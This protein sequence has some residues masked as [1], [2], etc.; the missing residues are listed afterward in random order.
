MQTVKRLIIKNQLYITGAVLYAA[1]LSFII[2]QTGI[3]TINE[4][5]K[6]ISA[7]QRI[8]SIDFTV[9]IS[10]H[11]F[12]FSYILFTA[13]LLS[14]GNITTIVIVQAV[15]SFVASIC[16]KK[17]L[18]LLQPI[19]LISFAGM[20]MFLFCYPVQVWVATLFSDSFFVSL[21]AITLYYT[22]KVKTK[23]EVYLWIF[24]NATLLFARPPGVFLLLVFILFQ[25]YKSNLLSKKQIYISFLTGLT[26]LVLSVFFIPVENKGYIQ[27][28]AA[29]RIIVDSSSYSLPDFTSKSKTNLKVAYLYLYEKKGFKHIASLYV[30]KCLSF[31]TLTRPHYSARH[32]LIV[33][34]FYLIYPFF[35]IG[36]IYLWAYGK[37]DIAVLLCAGIFILLNLVALTFNEWHYRFTIPAFPFLIIGAACTFSFLH[38]KYVAGN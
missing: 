12:Y 2:K 33:Q 27:P 36:L 24:L 3:I 34:L 29:G 5:E 35:I 15:L 8:F 7:A 13:L 10:D 1:F 14:V 11:L 38:Q 19:K 23:A 22:I 32:N 28:V 4:A 17:T 21:I 30:K 20:L 9:I 37:R 16:I 6:Y 31:F 25:F 26:G 18:D